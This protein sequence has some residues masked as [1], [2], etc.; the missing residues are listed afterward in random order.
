[1]LIGGPKPVWLFS[2]SHPLKLAGTAGTAG[3]GCG[4]VLFSIGCGVPGGGLGCPRRVGGG[5]RISGC[6]VLHNRGQ[7]EIE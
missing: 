3:T 6:K 1:V 5:D 7:F 4:S 2:L